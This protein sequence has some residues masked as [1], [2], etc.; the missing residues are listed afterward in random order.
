MRRCW[1]FMVLV[2]FASL[3]TSTAN[4]GRSCPLCV[5]PYCARSNFTGYCFC[6]TTSNGCDVIGSCSCYNQP[7]CTCDG[8]PPAAVKKTEV[9]DAQTDVL[10]AKVAEHPWLSSSSFANDLKVYS[11]AL[12]W[13]VRHVQGIFQGKQISAGKCMGKIGGGTVTDDGGMILYDLT[14]VGNQWTLVVARFDKAQAAAFHA[15]MNTGEIDPKK[16]FFGSPEATLHINGRNWKLQ[17]RE[18]TVNGIISD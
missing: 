9:A 8:G 13:S 10:S 17:Q 14:R 3:V 12:E 6:L 11:P 15:K 16:D 18:A 7:V 1:M 4:A 5:P 2:F